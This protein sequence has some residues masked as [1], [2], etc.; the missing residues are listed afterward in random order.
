MPASRRVRQ[1]S[2]FEKI[3]LIE[4]L[5]ASVAHGP[6]VRLGIG[7]DAAVLA[8]RGQLVWTVDAQVEGVHFRADWLSCEDI[9]YRATMAAVSDIAAMGA[10][11]VAA[12][13]SLALPSGF[14]DAKLERLVRGQAEAAR[15]AGC[16][17]VGGNITRASELGVT[18][19]VLGRAARPLLRSGARPGDELWLCGE[20]GAA[21]L[22]LAALQRGVRARRA[23][24]TCIER[25]RRPRALLEHG[26][27]LARRARA[28]IDISD[29]LAGDA[30]HLARASRV[31][32]VIDAFS[33]QSALAPHVVAAA[34]E[35]ELDGLAVALAGGEDYALLACGARARRP[36]EARLIGRV[37]RGA[38]VYLEQDRRRRELGSGFEHFSAAGRRS[39]ARGKKRAAGG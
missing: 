6:H 5:L 27:E 33:L 14:A 38:G 36:A 20:V 18:T 3:D 10:Q 19:T 16:P 30:A 28:S 22:G 37:E 4:R 29:G 23:L 21:A 17:L 7:D 35:L 32:L 26:A 39:S 2:E 11:P 31:R 25:W 1:R 12:L 9:G 24:K 13:A 34:A 15:L 8:A